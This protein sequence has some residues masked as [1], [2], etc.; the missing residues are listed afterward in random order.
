MLTAGPTAAAQSHALS[1]RGLIPRPSA[2]SVRQAIHEAELL[3]P[4]E[5][6][7]GG[8]DPRWQAI[9]AVGKHIEREPEAVWGF[10]WRWGSHP[11]EDLRDAIATCLLEHLL[12]HHFVAYFPQLEERALAEPLFGDTVLRCWRF[13]QAEEPGNIERFEALSK[14]LCEG[15]S[16][17][18]NDGHAG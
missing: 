14:R 2:M 4:G 15:K 18:R 3:L 12:Q 7:S 17:S 9:I 1:G 8:E 5:S 10:I 13:G 11:Q 6:A 16:V